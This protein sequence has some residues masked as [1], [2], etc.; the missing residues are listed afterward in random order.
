LIR[1]RIAAAA[2][3]SGRDPASITVVAASKGQSPERL[4]AAWE[5][6]ITVFGESRV[7]EGLAKI[8]HLPPSAEWHFIGPLQTNKVR[9]AVAAFGVFH[10]VDRLRLAEALA[11]EA[12]RLGR[13]LSCFLEINLACEPTKH[14]FSERDLDRELPRLA[15]LDGLRW[16]GLMAIPP[17]TPD[18]EA[19]RPWFRA[20][21]TLSG[22]IVER[23]ESARFAGALSMGM[24]SDFE[25][26]VEEGATHVRIGTA[27]FGPRPQTDT[28]GD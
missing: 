24:S 5:A 27:L 6:G 12:V 23:M 10:S 4:R 22:R 3:R 13:V 28:A 9:P 19:A 17:A 8:P 26:A 18:G 20:L 2:A 7:Q 1:E 11:R 25:V 16:L 14:G 21:R 15:R